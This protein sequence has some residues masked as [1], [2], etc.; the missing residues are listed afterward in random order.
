MKLDEI[1]GA[2]VMAYMDYMDGL[3]IGKKVRPLYDKLANELFQKGWRYGAW[4]GYTG[5]FFKDWYIVMMPQFAWAKKNMHNVKVIYRRPQGGGTPPDFAADM[6]DVGDMLA[7]FA[8][9]LQEVQDKA[10]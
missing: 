9:N 3:V 1:S 7:N 6:Y 5:C 4:Q 2:H 10:T 8:D